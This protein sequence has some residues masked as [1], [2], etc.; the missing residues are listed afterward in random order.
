MLIKS[1]ENIEQMNF[2][3]KSK[4]IDLNPTDIY[5]IN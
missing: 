5:D 1:K 4:S 2:K 3:N